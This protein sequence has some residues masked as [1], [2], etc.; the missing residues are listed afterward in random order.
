M[1]YTRILGDWSEVWTLR[2]GAELPVADCRPRAS[3]SVS[4]V[5]TGLTTFRPPSTGLSVPGRARSDTLTIAVSPSA[6]G[7][8][9]GVRQ[10]DGISSTLSWTSE[11][12]NAMSTSRNDPEGASPQV[13]RPLMASDVPDGTSAKKSRPVWKGRIRLSASSFTPGTSRDSAWPIAALAHA[14]RLDR[15]FPPLT[16]AASWR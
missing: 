8:A 14:T 6:T 3:P 2:P 1:R 10:L 16:S 9:G 4:A 5:R 15:L 12:S 11:P 7:T 13:S